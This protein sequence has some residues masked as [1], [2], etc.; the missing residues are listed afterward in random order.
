[1]KKEK[2]ETGFFHKYPKIRG[3]GHEDVKDILLAGKI[4]IQEKIDGANFRF[5]QKNGKI[6]FGSRTQPLGTEEDNI[7]GNWERC[8]EHIKNKTNKEILKELDP[9][10]QLVFYGENCVKHTVNYDWEKIPPFLGYDILDTAKKEFLPSNEAQRIY[11]AL[12]LDYVP[13]IWQGTTQ[14]IN[15]TH[16]EVPDSKYKNGKAEGIVIKN[17]TTGM[18]AK[19]VTPEFKEENWKTFGGGIKKANKYGKDEDVIVAKYCTNARIIKNIHKLED[20]GYKLDKT[21]MASLIKKVLQDIYTEQGISILMSSY[22]I[23]TKKLRGKIAKRCNAVLQQ[24]MINK[25]LNQQKEV[26][27]E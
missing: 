27:K 18:K 10:E 16:T 21:M 12:G 3:L 11:Q 24:E 15:K 7:G 13:V 9:N 19:V 14:E 2:I 4:T 8:V 22:K 20:D 1:M 25:A 5:K 26:K 6:I 23:D 17:E